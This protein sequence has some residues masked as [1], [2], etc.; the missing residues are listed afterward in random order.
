MLAIP[1]PVGHTID[2]DYHACVTSNTAGA[3][4]AK[5]RIFSP[6]DPTGSLTQFLK[7]GSALAG[8][9]YCGSLSYKYTNDTATPGIFGFDIKN[10]G[11]T[12]VTV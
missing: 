6:L 7:V 5:L 11:S 1:V 3:F 9:I 4:E 10:T 12:F 8:D 2:I